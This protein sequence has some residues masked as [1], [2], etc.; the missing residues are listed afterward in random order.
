MVCS[1]GTTG[2]N[3]AVLVLNRSYAAVRVVTVRR[4]FVLLY[5]DSAEV[6]HAENGAFFNYDFPTWC[7]LSQI[8]TE[9]CA[10]TG[11]NGHDWI[12]TVRLSIQ[13]PRIIRLIR[14]DRAPWSSIRLNRKTVFA[15]DGNRCQYCGRVY[16][17]N[18]LSLDH[19]TPRSRGGTTCWENVVTCCLR[20]NSHKGSKTPTEADMNL[21]QR[22]VA[23]RRNPILKRTLE[24]PRYQVWQPFLGQAEC[25][26]D[27]V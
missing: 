7:E 11:L 12:R 19:V 2:L 18:Q 26:V 5:R 21:V 22:P 9:Q 17:T 4:A 23:P 16:P 14:F 3:A 25:P 8:W 13:A 24:N 6:I 15:R 10:T 1:D 20:C 27:L